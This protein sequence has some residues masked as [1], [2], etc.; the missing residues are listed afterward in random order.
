MRRTDIFTMNNKRYGLLIYMAVIMMLLCFHT[1]T[2]RA[3]DPPPEPVVQVTPD[4]TSM[5]FHYA[6]IGESPENT[7]TLTN[8]SNIDAVITI[9]QI[10]ALTA[11][12]SIVTGSDNCSTKS[13]NP[14]ASCTVKLKYTPTAASVS[15]ANLN[16]TFKDPANNTYNV[17]QIALTGSGIKLTATPS[18]FDFGSATVGASVEKT[19][20]LK[21]DTVTA[22]LALTVGQ[23]A[24]TSPFSIVAGTD[25]CS[26]KVMNPADTCTVK[27]KYTPTAAV[28]TDMNYSLPYKDP[29]TTQH[30]LTVPLKGKGVAQP[31]TGGGGGGGGGG[32][33]F[34]ATAAYGS[35]LHPDVKVL[36]EFRDRWL[37]GDFRIK[38]GD[39]VF[40][41]SNTAGRA[42]VKTYYRLS[43]PVANYIAQHESLKTITRIALAP[44]VYTVKYPLS[45][46]MVLVTGVAIVVRRRRK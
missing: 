6:A 30:T 13:L 21:N 4:Q 16:I 19:L 25:N 28:Q 22:A 42:F 31:T 18:P 38:V 46:G 23:I 44:V 10:P 36:K 40:T 12:F 9:Q 27:L 2:L 3:A 32:G 5:D 37:L 43:P 45:A 35:Y 26:N 11:P 41:F 20:T 34:I 14:N 1:G 29:D 7:L 24:M 33:C 15:N 17:P 39:S 8:T